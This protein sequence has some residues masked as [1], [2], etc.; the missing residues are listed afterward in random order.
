MNTAELPDFTIHGF[1]TGRKIRYQSRTGKWYEGIYQGWGIFGSGA[2][3][4]QQDDVIAWEPIVQPW[5]PMGP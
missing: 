2:Q 4:L 3:E 1:H 5:E